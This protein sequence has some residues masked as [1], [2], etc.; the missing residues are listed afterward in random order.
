MIGRKDG[1]IIRKGG[2]KKQKVNVQDQPTDR[3]LANTAVW[4]AA[5]TTWLHVHAQT[6]TCCTRHENDKVRKK[7]A[8]PLIAV[9]NETFGGSSL[10]L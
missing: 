2:E 9:R 8:K 4:Q 3:V 10:I 6:N 5:K 1:Q 7:G